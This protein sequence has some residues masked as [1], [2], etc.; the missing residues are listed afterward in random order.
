MN[1]NMSITYSHT[2]NIISKEMSKANDKKRTTT[3][4]STENYVKNHSNNTKII[5][6][7]RAFSHIHTL[8]NTLSV[9]PTLF[10]SAY[11]MLNEA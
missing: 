6:N 4:H 7:A 1:K 9:S 2:G 3:Q 11:T 8:T 5:L 10:P